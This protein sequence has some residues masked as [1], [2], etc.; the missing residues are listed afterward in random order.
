MGGAPEGFDARILVRELARGPV[1]HVAR[2][3]KRAEATRVAL[4]VMAPEVAVLDFPAWDCLPFD[5]VSPN[6]EISARRMATLSA[7]ADGLAG[8]FILV[9]TLNAATQRVPTR[10]VVRAASFRAVVGERVDEARL[11]GFLAR[12]G[13]SPVS[14]VA[15]PGDYA[16][17]G[18]IVDIYPPGPGGPIRL[19]FFGDVL[20]GARR[21][22]PETQRTIETLKRVEFSA[23]SEVIL[24]DAAIARF[25]QNY[26]ISFGAA[27]TD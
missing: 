19:D 23:V 17:R 8:P 15:E 20:D 22:D 11:K 16:L 26:R 7:L 2:D 27:G 21:F 10:E 1:V 9:T 13:F 24:D 5:R 25:R 6:P 12:M 14:T 18:G 4:A 3:D